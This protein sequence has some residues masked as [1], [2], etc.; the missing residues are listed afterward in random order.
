MVAGM[1]NPLFLATRSLNACVRSTRTHSPCLSTE[2]LPNALQTGLFTIW[3]LLYTVKLTQHAVHGRSPVTN[4][5]RTPVAGAETLVSLWSRRTFYLHRAGLELGRPREGVYGVDG[6]DVGRHLVRE[7]V[8]QENKPGT[9]SVG[10]AGFHPWHGPAPRT[11]L[12]EVAVFDAVLGGVFLADLQ[13]LFWVFDLLV[14]LGHGARVVEGEAAAG[15]Q[16]EGV[17]FVRHLHRPLVVH[18]GEGGSIL[19]LL[20]P[21]V[22]VQEFGAHPGLLHDV[23]GDRRALGV[24]G[25]PGAGGQ[26]L[27]GGVVRDLLEAAVEAGPLDATVLLEPLVAHTGELGC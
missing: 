24:L 11:Y 6:K 19:D 18:G 10:D 15:R 7:A 23:G 26:L 1:M 8:A 22:G 9:D 20:G 4:E 16:L 13:Q 12:H 25:A 5:R 14:I 2:L 21:E 27:L 3:Q 17:L